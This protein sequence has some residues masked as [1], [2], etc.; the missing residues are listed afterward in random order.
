M[1]SARI[2]AAAGALA[3]LWVVAGCATLETGTGNSVRGL[4]Y[5]LQEITEPRPNRAHILRVDL[6]SGAL[7][8]A[9]VVADDPDGSGPAEAALTS[10][11]R[12]AAKGPVKAFVNTNPWDDVPD[13]NGE[14]TRAWHEGQP[15]DIHGLAA[16][17]GEIR[18]MA[19]A[20]NV[21]V[22]VNERGVVALGDGP[23][24]E[25]VVEGMSGFGQIV[26]DGVLIPPPEGPLHPRT[27]L[28]LDRT[29]TILWLVVVDGRQPEFSEGMS[30]HELGQLMLVLGCWNA[31]NMDGG[32]SSV[33]G[34]AAE[35]GR[36]QVVNSPSDRSKADPNTPKIRPLPMILTIL[37]K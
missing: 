35:N 2:P 24:E 20:G 27:A 28:G 12:L 4:D 6:S 8:L 16:S 7:A 26:R 31:A 17:N 13:D 11:L 32:G 5:R 22:W 15:V 34:L 33:M 1:S 9:V 3:A 18:S 37:E 30:E 36:L 19:Q 14:K 21:A 29:G 10:P 23:G 25:T